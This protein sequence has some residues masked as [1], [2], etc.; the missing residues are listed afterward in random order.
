MIDPKDILIITDTQ[1]N[2]LGITGPNWFGNN[3]LSLLFC[4]GSSI[5]VVVKYTH[6]IESLEELH[7]TVES[8]KSKIATMKENI[9]KNKSNI[10]EQEQSIKS[11]LALE[12]IKSSRSGKYFV[13]MYKKYREKEE[14]WDYYDC[15][16][17]KDLL[18]KDN[19]VFI[20]H[21]SNPF[22]Y[23]ADPNLLEF[24]VK[25][26]VE[27]KFL[28]NNKVDERYRGKKVR[29]VVNNLMTYS[30]G[31]D[32]N[33]LALTPVTD[34]W[35]HKDI[36]ILDPAYRFEC[37][38]IDLFPE[39]RRP[40]Y[41]WGKKN[42]KIEKVGE[43]EQLPLIHGSTDLEKITTVQPEDYTLHYNLNND[44]V[45][46]IGQGY[47]WRSVK[48]CT[49]TD[50]KDGIKFLKEN[51]E[52]LKKTGTDLQDKLEETE[53]MIEPGILSKYEEI[54]KCHTIKESE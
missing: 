2:M 23:N 9:V 32:L 14:N 6:S 36:I 17:V 19:T 38:M 40:F 54:I 30:W 12:V 22:F 50:V 3:Y 39:N 16:S 26:I 53:R 37:L 35:T 10:E 48:I 34:G 13:D 7:A 20:P 1:N 46:G 11:L 28:N 5:T 49:S 41:G 51:I 31:G 18:V 42:V 33:R 44:R 52:D 27:L 8:L 29:F 47:H 24:K 4:N 21:R 15:E 45:V 43:V 25:D